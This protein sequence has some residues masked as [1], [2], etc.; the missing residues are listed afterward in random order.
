MIDVTTGNIL[1]ES[2]NFLVGPSL[3]REEFLTSPLAIASRASAKN[4]PR[5]SFIAKA[6]RI[7][8]HPFIIAFYFNGSVLTDLE[9]SSDDNK[10]GTS[11]EDWSEERELE[12]KKFHDTWLNNVLGDAPYRYN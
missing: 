2:I 10:F 3:T 4:E 12:R 11:W 1:V 9:L 7:A 6:Q 5:C 8:G